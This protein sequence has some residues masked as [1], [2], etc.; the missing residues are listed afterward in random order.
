MSV[1]VSGLTS[2]G[3]LLLGSIIDGVSLIR[4]TSDHSLLP[5]SP[6][7]LFEAES[8]SGEHEE[9]PHLSEERRQSLLI[10]Q[11]HLPSADTP[12]ASSINFERK[13]TNSLAAALQHIDP[14][15]VPS[16]SF[17]RHSGVLLEIDE[18]G[19][20]PSPNPP[21]SSEGAES[22]ISSLLIL[23]PQV[24]MSSPSKHSSAL[25]RLRQLEDELR[26]SGAV[27]PPD[28]AVSDAVARALAAAPPSTDL[29]IRVNQSR[30]TTTTKTVYETETPGMA[31]LDWEKIRELQRQMIQALC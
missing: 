5:S 23:L 25:E 24:A 9:V 19:R 7:A 14:S 16:L 22:I 6:T 26:E 29:Q 1:V 18:E 2:S 28:A 20:S 8:W 21:I 11:P 31:N 4:V 15:G 17:V 3:D 10:D 13:R 12:I 30:H 27:C